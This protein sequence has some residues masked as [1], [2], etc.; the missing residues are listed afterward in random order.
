MKILSIGN[1]FSQDAQRYLNRVAAAQG[2]DLQTTNLFIGG[3]SLQMHY[4]NICADAVAY[5]VEKNGTSTGEK[6]SILAALQSEAWDVVTVQQASHL[7]NRF[8]HYEPYLLPLA[9]YVRA[10]CPSAKLYVHQTWGYEDASRRLHDRGYGSMAAM[11]ADVV[12]C[13]DRAA[14]LVAADGIIPCS[15]AMLAA[16]Q[17][18][19][20]VHRDTFHADLGIG[21]YL[22]ALTWLRTLTDADISQN[23]FSDFDEPVTEEQR[24][25]AIAAV[26]SVT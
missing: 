23:N 21:R 14:A 1:S 18:G 16:Y 19:M 15:R 17:S 4:E 12:K 2:Y 9:D 8:E 6:T 20:R 5:D 25:N 10:H 3:C 26:L 24:K 13:Y 11:T 7:S 22:L